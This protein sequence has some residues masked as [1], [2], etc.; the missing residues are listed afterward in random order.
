MA[1]TVNYTQE[2][3]DALIDKLNIKYN[4]LVCK[5]AKK[6]I[7]KVGFCDTSLLKELF[8]YKWALSYW[9][10][11]PSGS[12]TGKD[13]YLTQEQFNCITFRLKS[14]TC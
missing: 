14:I 8:L 4:S 3:L 9:E 13:N 1:V 6:N 10:Q 12:T 11:N 2:E 7:Y 5:L